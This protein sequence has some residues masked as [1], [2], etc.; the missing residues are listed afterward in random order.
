VPDE[1]VLDELVLDESVLLGLFAA[2]A[3]V[4][5]SLPVPGLLELLDDGSG[6]AGA[7]FVAPGAFGSPAGAPE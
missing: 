4:V 1:S 5:P 2:G 7:A 6:L 3:V